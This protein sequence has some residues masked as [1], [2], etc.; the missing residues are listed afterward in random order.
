[1]D[2][3]WKETDVSSSVVVVRGIQTGVGDGALLVLLTV[4]GEEVGKRRPRM[5]GEGGF[6]GGEENSAHSRGW[7][8]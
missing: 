4:E 2:T 8:L 1:V 7:S 6:G 5:E 3:D